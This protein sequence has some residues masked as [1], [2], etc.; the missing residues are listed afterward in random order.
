ME[1]DEV[2]LNCRDA[3]QALTVFP[4]SASSG[5]FKGSWGSVQGGCGRASRRRELTSSTQAHAVLQ[6]S[7]PSDLNLSVIRHKLK[8][9]GSHSVPSS[10]LPPP[11]PNAQFASPHASENRPPLPEKALPLSTAM[12][13]LGIGGVPRGLTPPPTGGSSY[14]Q[15]S[16][17]DA[18][19][20]M[21]QQQLQGPPQQQLYDTPSYPSNTPRSRTASPLPAA[22]GFADSSLSPST[23]TS[24]RLEAPLAR[25]ESF[26]LPASPHLEDEWREQRRVASDNHAQVKARAAAASLREDEEREA[27]EVERRN[28]ELKER[29]EA[30]RLDGEK[31]EREAV[32]QAK[33]DAEK[34]ARARWESEQKERERLD[35]EERK[36][37]EEEEMER[38]EAADRL[39]REETRRAEVVAKERQR[40]E[41][42]R[43]AKEEE[44][45]SRAA[46]EKMR[47]LIEHE[48]MEKKLREEEEIR[49]K[50][51]ERMKEREDLKLRWTTQKDG[52]SMLCGSVTCQHTSVVSLF[53]LYLRTSLIS[54][55]QIWRRRWFELKSDRLLLFKSEK[56]T[57]SSSLVL[58]RTYASLCRIRLNLSMSSSFRTSSRA[59]LPTPRRRKASLFR[60]SSYSRPRTRIRTCSTPTRKCVLL[61]SFLPAV[62]SRV[63][64]V[65][66]RQGT[67]DH[68]APDGC[69]VLSPCWLQLAT[70]STVVP[71]VPL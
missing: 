70:S 26:P 54:S 66:G 51:E 3:V 53:S 15:R 47:L 45:R 36:R 29:E 32:E 69:E 38:R 20:S 59:S 34:E 46:K 31:R 42:E 19:S 28:Q 57:S 67:V 27:L 12:A 40:V 39:Q 5:T 9:D 50:E 58:S 65:P 10:P 48:R 21:R 52:E 41:D 33:E 24:A 16:P 13:G 22:S 60:S 11:S 64:L 43:A 4:T 23:S 18:G 17:Y 8:L 44:E 61:S 37:L 63:F 56:V 6:V 71:A 35:L 30:S 2:S 55:I 68:W 49:R 7:K 14:S 1:F 25:S 62:C